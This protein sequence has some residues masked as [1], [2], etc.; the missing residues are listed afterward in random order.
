MN[1]LIFFDF[2]EFSEFSEAGEQ[3]K[4][5]L[6][7]VD[8]TPLRWHIPEKYIDWVLTFGFRPFHPPFMEQIDGTPGCAMV[9]GCHLI[10]FFDFWRLC[11]ISFQKVVCHL[12]WPR[13]H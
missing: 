8:L 13:I 4:K 7:R 11:H 9:F 12:T 3:K 1:F 10:L 2:S 6:L 5:S